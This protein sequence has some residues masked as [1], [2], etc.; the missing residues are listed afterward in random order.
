MDLSLESTFGLAPMVAAWLMVPVAAFG[1]GTL[2]GPVPGIL[3]LLAVGAAIGLINGFM[4]VKFRLNGFIWTLA[5]TII[6]D[7]FQDGIVNGQIASR[8]A[9]RVELPRLRLLRVR[10]RCRWFS[11]P[12]SSSASGCSCATTDG[13]ATSMRSAATRG[14]ARRRHSR[15]PHPHRRLRRR[16]RARRD[17]RPDGG[18]SRIGGGQHAGL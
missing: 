16:Q 5:M 15:R 2:W 4:I 14:S 18:R 6:L 7:G 3:V 1:A 9:G 13:G 17:R 12:W 10:S 11:P 8:R